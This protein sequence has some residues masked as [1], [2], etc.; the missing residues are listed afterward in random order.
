MNISS[1]LARLMRTASAISLLA[2]AVGC[3]TATDNQPTNA[4]AT[5]ADV[6]KQERVARL[7]RFCERL[8]NAGD[9]AVAVGMCGRAYEIDPENIEPLLELADTL[10]LMERNQ[11][12]AQ[13]YRRALTIEPGNIRATFSLGKV[14]MTLQQYDLAMRQ[15]ES[16]LAQN[17]Q[18]QRIYN[19][20][21]VVKDLQGEHKAAQAYYR[22]GLELAPGDRSLRSNLGLSLSLSGDHEAAVAMLDG[23]AN[24]PAA[25]A[26]S[27][28]NLALAYGLAGDS[29]AAERIGRIDLP[30][31]AVA[32]NLDFYNQRRQQARPEPTP[33]ATAAP[34]SSAP[35]SAVD[36]RP[37][38]S[39]APKD[40]AAK[41][42]EP[43]APVEPVRA[44]EPV[45]ETALRTSSPT[46]AEAA[47]RRETSPLPIAT[48]SEPDAS[49]QRTAVAS[50]RMRL[51]DPA[52]ADDVK[53]GPGVR[54]HALP[55]P[56][57]IPI[58][59][60]VAPP[61]RVALA[62]EAAPPADRVAVSPDDD[63]QVAPTAPASYGSSADRQVANSTA[64]LAPTV[65]PVALDMAPAGHSGA[66]S[67]SQV[68]PLPD[69]ASEVAATAAKPS[70]APVRHPART[71]PEPMVITALD[72][73]EQAKSPAAIAETDQKVAS[74]AT[75]GGEP[76]F[77]LKLGSY[78]D[79]ERSRKA[80]RD[81]VAVAPDLLVDVESVVQRT[82]IGIDAGT[83]Y[84]L[85][86]TPFRDKA[87]AEAACTALLAK[88]VY[89]VIVSA[90]PDGQQPAGTP[91]LTERMVTEAAE[92]AA[93][94]PTKAT[95]RLSVGDAAES[96]G[97]PTWTAGG[98]TDDMAAPSPAAEAADPAAPMPIEPAAGAA[99]E[100]ASMPAQTEVQPSSDA[101]V[102]VENDGGMGRL[103]R[104]A[105]APSGAGRDLTGGQTKAPSA[106]AIRYRLQ[107]G[108]F[109]R[110]AFAKR[111]WRKLESKAPDLLSGIDQFVERVDLGAEKG[112]YFRLRTA[113]MADRSAANGLCAELKGREIDCLVVRAPADTTPDADAADADQTTEPEV[114]TAANNQ[115]SRV[116]SIATDPDQAAVRYSVQFGAY[117]DAEAL[118]QQWRQ[119]KDLAPDLLAGIEPVVQRTAISEAEGPYFRLRTEQLA[120]RDGAEGLCTALQARGVACVVV[121]LTTQDQV[122]PQIA[123]DR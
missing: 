117:R 39:P 87:Q 75:I 42:A 81:I 26:T 83:F 58:D 46:H 34:L 115:P 56:A 120:G 55:S 72:A 76:Q 36:N 61:T 122:Q 1:S 86:T 38:A 77:S 79:T 82:D 105:R 91:S 84:R 14:Y 112:V 57:M 4:A 103:T 35:P 10:A 48:P 119:L 73:P 44:S 78:L 92:P 20:I 40:L 23:F 64:T 98:E 65:P 62:P 29:A 59:Q 6:A 47:T 101:P 32:Q 7:L 51:A 118:K 94:E 18:D 19:V 68:R 69:P 27:R 54:Q 13:A 95:A 74:A 108:A 85:G 114:D 102:A 49:N 67:P 107:L 31:D 121:G 106:N 17:H 109:R 60:P 111:V 21:G 104:V 70:K 5:P 9:M 71:S 116:D 52:P 22:S 8:R 33:P 66:G 88:G 110:E 113:P 45:T 16:V 12:A 100:A 63:R 96:T 43:A 97:L 53:P 2:L 99:D 90:T 15:F 28:Q 89:C 11:E 24:D 30:A 41:A 3:T 37:T 80:W 93:P 25:G 50:P 123:T